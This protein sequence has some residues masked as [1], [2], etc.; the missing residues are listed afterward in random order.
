M[1]VPDIDGFVYIKSNEEEGK[2]I[3][4]NTFRECIINGIKEYDLIGEFK[5]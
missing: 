3:E 1:D 5:K 4:I 2:S